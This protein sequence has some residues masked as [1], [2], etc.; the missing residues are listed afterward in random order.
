VREA[1]PN[2]A[3]EKERIT[4]STRDVLLN[5]SFVLLVQ[6]PVKKDE[7]LTLAI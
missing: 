7:K 1:V 4:F 3:S 5:L 2:G 6:E